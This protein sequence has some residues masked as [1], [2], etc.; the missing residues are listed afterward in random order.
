MQSEPIM[1][2][3]RYR[4]LLARLLFY[5]V[6]RERVAD[7]LRAIQPHKDRSRFLIEPS[8]PN[9][10][11]GGRFALTPTKLGTMCRLVLC[12]SWTFR[13]SVQG[14]RQWSKRMIARRVA[15]PFDGVK[16]GAEKSVKPCPAVKCCPL[17]DKS[18]LRD[19]LTASHG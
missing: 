6:Q 8:R 10:F 4:Y 3:V 18:R 5:R 7:N 13:C 12:R 11:I 9:G 1:F 14:W 2:A 19:H 17:R 15:A 16:Q